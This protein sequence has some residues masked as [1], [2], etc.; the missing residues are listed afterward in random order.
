MH[1]CTFLTTTSKSGA[2]ERKKVLGHDRDAVQQMYKQKEFFNIDYTLHLLPKVTGIEWICIICRQ[3]SNTHGQLITLKVSS[4]AQRR[5][6]N[7]TQHKSN[8]KAKKE[9]GQTVD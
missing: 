2:I 6:T 3:C 7:K 1:A 9:R 4:K 8:K 5:S